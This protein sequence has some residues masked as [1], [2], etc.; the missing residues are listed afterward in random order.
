MVMQAHRGPGLKLWYQTPSVTDFP[1]AT[2]LGSAALTSTSPPAMAGIR[3]KTTIAAARPI[4]PRA[5]DARRLFSRARI[6][7]IVASR[8]GAHSKWTIGK[9]TC[10]LARHARQ[11]QTGSHVVG[12]S[13]RSAP[14]FGEPVPHPALVSSPS[15]ASFDSVVLAVARQHPWL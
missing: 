3:S 1:Q 15:W 8:T 6:Y 12:S 10:D 13:T 4:W 5:K 7:H 2:V 9:A 11:T 14:G